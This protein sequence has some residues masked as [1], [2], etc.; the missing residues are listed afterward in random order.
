MNFGRISALATLILLTGLLFAPALS[1]T[2]HAADI[3]ENPNQA[4]FRVL[5]ECDASL[6]ITSD[7]TEKGGP[8][9]FSKFQE[10]VV[11]AIKWLLYILIPIAFCLIGWAGFKIMTAGGSGEN[12]QEAY[13]MIKIV[14]IGIIIAAV[15]YIVIVNIFSL[16]NVKDVTFTPLT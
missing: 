14:V 3:P 1:P 9:G 12:V 13:G 6:F 15:S 8:C 4:G 2:T 16:L 10:M 11:R 5:P 7:S